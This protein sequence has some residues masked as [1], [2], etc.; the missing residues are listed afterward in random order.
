MVYVN[1]KPGRTT[2]VDGEEYLFFTGYNYLGISS[3]PEFIELLQE[4]LHRYGWL[5]PSSRISNT[6]LG[7]YSDCEALL[8]RLTGSEDT[9]LL[10]SGFTAGQVA[11]SL[12]SDHL[13][14]A[15]ASH[16]AILRTR[17]A[18]TDFEKWIF[19][20]LNE[21]SLQQ[22]PMLAI[23]ADS[24]NPLTA[25]IHDFGFLK[26]LTRD[27]TVIIDDSHGIGVTGKDGSGAASVIPRTPNI[28][29]TLT[30]SLSKGFG[31]AG[32]AVSCSKETAEQLR[33][34][35]EYT[36]VTPQSPA[37]L[38]AFLHGQH[39]YERQRQKLKDN[40]RAFAERIDGLPGIHYTPDFPVFILDDRY[41]EQQL[42]SDKI[43]ISSFAYPDPAGKKL[44]RIVINALH[45][46]DDLDKLAGCL[47]KTHHQ[48]PAKTSFI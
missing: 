1:Q 31:I 32:G 24:L 25:T 17:P 5:F 7:L 35:P 43:L 16:P 12:H 42:L 11:T 30:Y 20:L 28:D 14:N 39:I 27:I 44:N 8:S 18:L 29:Y 38:H 36:A 4:G 45:T 22:S 9:V 34:M 2:Y 6:R 40:I 15:P 46:G 21:Q 23:A 48:K 47:T 26:K 3:E 19:W 10:P 33:T 37:Q 41:T 13:I